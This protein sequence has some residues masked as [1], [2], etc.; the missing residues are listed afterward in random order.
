VISEFDGG[1]ARKGKGFGERNFRACPPNRQLRWRGSP[2]SLQTAK[3]PVKNIGSEHIL[4]K[5][6]FI[7]II[8]QSC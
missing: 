1:Q 6:F 3:E 4:Q 5:K 7:D 8:T 2:Q